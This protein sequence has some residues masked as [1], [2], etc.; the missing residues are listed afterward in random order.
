M[1]E[2]PSVLVTA[3]ET[4]TTVT[5]YTVGV[6]RGLRRFAGKQPVGTASGVVL[7]VIIL[8]AVASPWIA[9]YNPIEGHFTAIN[10]PP[11]SEY[12]L[13][14][15][16]VGRDVL[17][18]V[19]YGARISLLVA[20]VAVLVGDTLGAMWGIASGY[21]GG[22]FDI[23]SQRIIEL[24]LAFP[25][26]I[27]AMVL[28][29]GL[30]AG[31]FTV[32]LAIAIT[33]IPLSVRVIRSVS[34]SVKENSYV[35]AAR[36]IG[37]SE[38]RIMALHIAPQCLAPWLVLVTA[39]LGGVIV[40]EASL[41]FLGVG[42]PA[43]TATWGNML[44]GAVAATLKP[45]WWLVIFPGVAITIT[46]LAFNLFGDSIRDALDPRLRGNT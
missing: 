31:V 28:L 7:A 34:L 4:V 23:Y 16:R 29:L 18:R 15:D 26:L 35:E 8:V 5:G 14:T 24:L 25:T 2:N 39:Q 43:P 13:G 6:L 36:A 42:V 41:G 17:S 33:R 37:A 3:P 21:L 10:D 20:F 19:I 32:L 40:L 38:V 22:K 11:D 46:V 12:L 45:E 44:G 1:A 30:G 27:L 9:P